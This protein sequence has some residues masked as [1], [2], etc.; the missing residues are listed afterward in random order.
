MIAINTQNAPKVVGP[1]S[2]ASLNNGLLFISG[3]LGFD[4]KTSLLLGG[5]EAQAEQVFKNLEAVLKEADFTFTN[6][7]KVSVFLQSMNDFTSLNSIYAKYF[8]E[9]YP[10]REAIEVA[11][12][13]KGGLVEI[14]LIAMK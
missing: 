3:Q 13:P 9:P 5:F 8:T 4:P 12:L 11:T 14:S 7:M 10:A 2:Q 6:V 1:Y